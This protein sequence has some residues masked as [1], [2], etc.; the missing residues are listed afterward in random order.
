MGSLKLQCQK[1]HT[2]LQSELGAPRGRLDT[3][4]TKT[5]QD[6]SRASSASRAGSALANEF[7]ERLSILE[8]E[9]AS[10]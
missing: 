7:S 5:S 2:V 9:L 10:L 1:Q 4:E 8:L 3:A 6:V